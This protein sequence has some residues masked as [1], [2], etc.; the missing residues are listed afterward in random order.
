VIC[1]FLLVFDGC[2]ISAMSL[3]GVDMLEWEV[4]LNVMCCSLC[5]SNWLVVMMHQVP[6]SSEI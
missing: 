6:L 2:F 1:W 3:E 4:N 5:V